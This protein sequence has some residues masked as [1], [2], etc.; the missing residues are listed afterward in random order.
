MSDLNIASLKKDTAS[1]NKLSELTGLDR[2]TVKGYLE[3]EEVESMGQTK[4]GGEMFP[5]V[6]SIK[7]L[8][9]A[10]KGQNSADRRNDAQAEKAEVETLI[11]RRK[12]ITVEDFM[13]LIRPRFTAIAKHVERS[14]MEDELKETLV[15]VIL[16]EFPEI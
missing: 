13:T 2:R 9:N 7:A 5:V 6:E 8:I 3:N 4:Q 15:D 14:S 1:I 12:Y 10:K 11:L 16:K